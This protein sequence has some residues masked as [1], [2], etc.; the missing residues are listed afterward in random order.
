VIGQDAE[1]Q[2]LLKVLLMGD[3]SLEPSDVYTQQAEIARAIVV[4]GQP[5]FTHQPTARGAL[6]SQPNLYTE[7]VFFCK[8]ILEPF[9]V[10]V[11]VATFK[12]GSTPEGS[13]LRNVLD[14]L[15]LRNNLEG[16]DMRLGITKTP[17]YLRISCVT[18]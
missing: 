15:L 17:I 12:Y 2:R 9:R 14:F 3:F 13:A 5:R 10:N 18:P 8:T 4:D 7:E 16:E 1:K 11:T 6:T